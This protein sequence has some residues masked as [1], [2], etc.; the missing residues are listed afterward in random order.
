VYAPA[1][2]SSE[3]SADV[4][5]SFRSYCG[6]CKATI[7]IFV[8]VP[9]VVIAIS[10]LMGGLLAWEEQWTFEDGFY[11]VCGNLAQLATP[12]TNVTPDTDRGKIFDVLVAVWSL[13]LAGCFI[14]FIGSFSVVEA[15]P[16]WMEG[17]QFT[18][19]TETLYRVHKLRDRVQVFVDEED[20]AGQAKLSPEQLNELAQLVAAKI[21]AAA[22][23]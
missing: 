4:E 19:V 1:P 8:L 6:L 23:K 18:D 13:S 20:A 15:I 22:S 3:S 21:Q 12:L 10:V 16:E 14:G 11:Y 5:P 9:T 7:F 2:E 17:R